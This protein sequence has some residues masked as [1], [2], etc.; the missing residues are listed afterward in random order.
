MIQQ[1]LAAA[2][3][4]VHRA[5]EVILSY[6]SSHYEVQSKGEDNP[7]TTADLAAN[8]VLRETLLGAFPEAGWL[9]E[10][11]ADNAARLQH[12]YVW[13]IDP[14]DGTKEFIQ[15]IDEFVIVVAF[16][17]QQQVISST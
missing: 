5:G 13:I 10:E 17:V 9:S 2:K 8:H 16:V 3:E 14:I 4:A 7:V 6:Y 12:D 11:S 15:G 1:A